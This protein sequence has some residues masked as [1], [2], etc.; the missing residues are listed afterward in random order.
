MYVYVVVQEKESYY[1]DGVGGRIKARLEE[2]S[3]ERC[4]IVPYQEFNMAV[5]RELRPRAIT[6]SGFG[7]HFQQRRV[8]WFLGMNE[9]L[10]E[11]NIPT[12][13][14]CGS[15][16]LMGFAFNKDLTQ[17]SLLE[18]EPMRRIGP[19]EDLPRYAQQSSDVDLSG[20][21]MT[22]GFFP[23]WQVKDDPLFAGLPKVMIMRCN[24]YCEVKQLPPGF[25]LLAT[26]KH[27]R[28]E[29]MRH[30][31]RPLYGTQFHPEAYEPPFFDGRTL[32]KNF[33]RI[34]QDFW[35]AQPNT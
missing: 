32:L 35:S 15:H 30:A 1:R 27:C 10:H 12:L 8:E 25:E 23:I 6:M 4:L 29:A 5:V 7:G 3:G 26:S 2:A 16:Q 20:F 18:D 14:F 34:V 22:D 19:E 24:H 9:V 11:A 31:T 28:I 17:V 21:Y 13:A 33:A